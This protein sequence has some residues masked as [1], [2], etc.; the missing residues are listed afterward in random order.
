MKYT[1]QLSEGIKEWPELER[2]D[3]YSREHVKN[4]LHIYPGL[5]LEG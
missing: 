4:G 2:Q 1:K 3:L 5:F